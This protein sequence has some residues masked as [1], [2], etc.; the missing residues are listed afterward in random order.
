MSMPKARGDDSLALLSEGYRFG[1]HRFD[2]LG[3]D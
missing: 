3:T 2:R 1:Q